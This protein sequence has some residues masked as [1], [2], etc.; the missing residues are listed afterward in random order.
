M[1]FPSVCV[2]S[3]TLHHWQQLAQPHLGVILDARPGVISKGY[4]PLELELEAVYPCWG[5]LEEDEPGEQYFQ[6]LPTT[7]AAA[8]ATTSPM[9][10]CPTTTTAVSQ[11]DPG[12]C[13]AHTS[14]TYT[15]TTCRIL[16]PTDEQTRVTPRYPP[17]TT[18][19]HTPPSV[20]SWFWS[21][22]LAAPIATPCTLRRLSLRPSESSTNLRQ[23]S[24]TSR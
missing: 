21:S 24:Y 1:C 19:Y 9:L 18:T 2:G 23:A 3:A 10:P 20:E 4:R 15:F 16:H 7:S 8:T 12:K 17:P 11:S 5:G 13:M 14:S 6:N 22:L